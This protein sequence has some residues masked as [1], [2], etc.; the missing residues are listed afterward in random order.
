[1]FGLFSNGEE[2]RQAVKNVPSTHYRLQPVPM[3]RYW[4]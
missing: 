1:M 2:H 3:L 4:L